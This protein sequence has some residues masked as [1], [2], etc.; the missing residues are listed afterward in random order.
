M[1]IFD[2]DEQA[3]KTVAKGMTGLKVSIVQSS[4]L[5]LE[6]S[7]KG[8]VCHHRLCIVDVLVS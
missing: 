4:A 7:E 6:E 1:C 5:E 8:T 2:C 3:V